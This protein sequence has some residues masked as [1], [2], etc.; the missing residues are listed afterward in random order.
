MNWSVQS[1]NFD[2][3]V[4]GTLFYFELRDIGLNASLTSNFFK[5]SK[6]APPNPTIACSSNAATT[7]IINTTTQTISTT[8]NAQPSEIQVLEQ[9][10]RM[11]GIGLGIGL[12]IPLI[13]ALGSIALLFISSRCS[14]IEQ[15]QGNRDG[16]GLL[17]VTKGEHRQDDFYKAEASSESEIFE[18]PHFERV[19]E[20]PD[21][22]HVV[23]FG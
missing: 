15:N 2:L 16:H 3:D 23:R 18:A 11:I 22:G 5:I 13:L 9:K 8:E 7:I 4:P 6:E 1:Y 12:G 19:H 17:N 20:A 14:R 21:G 10:A